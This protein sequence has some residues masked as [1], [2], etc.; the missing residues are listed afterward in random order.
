MLTRAELEKKTILAVHGSP[1]SHNDF[2]QLIPKLMAKNYRFIGVNFPGH[3]RTSI[4][5]YR[6]IFRHKTAEKME[7][8]EDFLQT[9]NVPKVDLYLSHSAGAY[10]LVNYLAEYRPDAALFMINSLGATPNRVIRPYWLISRLGNI[11][12]TWPGRWLLRPFWYATC[13]FSFGPIKNV[14]Y[15]AVVYAMASGIGYDK[16]PKLLQSVAESHSRPI[17]HLYSKN[18]HLIEPEKSAEFASHLGIG[19]RKNF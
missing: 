3:G 9:L 16:I 10:P 11:Y 17:F 1:G 2:R 12:Q 8:L 19:K 15:A 5:P 7:F 4:D 13:R 18:D 6:G 14:D